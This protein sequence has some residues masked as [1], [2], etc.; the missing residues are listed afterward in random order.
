M[1]LTRRFGAQVRFTGHKDRLS[2][3]S[4][5]ETTCDSLLADGRRPYL[6]PRGGASRVGC[7]GYVEAALELQT[8]LE[9]GHIEPERLYLATGSCGTQAGLILGA[10]LARATYQVTGASVSR[11]PDECRSRIA[12]LVLDCAML[13]GIGHVEHTEQIHLLDC[14]G[15]RY[16][17]PSPEGEAAAALAAAYEGLVLDRVF[18]AKAMAALVDDARSKKVVGPVVFLHTGGTG[19]LLGGD[20]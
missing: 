18:T 17:K 16:G 10:S 1:R 6:I 8:Q 19:S 5:I 9:E 7:I 12:D 11:S 3:D 2:V 20:M 14:R 13:T 4:E 15:P